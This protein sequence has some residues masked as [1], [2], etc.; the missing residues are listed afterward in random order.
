MQQQ[1][2]PMER[3]SHV[4]ASKY[5]CT[6]PRYTSYP[7]APQF[8]ETFPL[9]GYLRD[10][11]SGPK[12]AD[13]PMSLYVHIPFCRDICYYCA[14][15]KIVTREE[16]AGR[17]YLDHLSKELQLLESLSYKSRPITQLHWGGGTPTYLDNAELTELMHMLSRN[18]KLRDDD[19]REY[20]VEIDPRNV[21][22]DKIALLKGLGFNRI[23]MGIQDF[24]PL[25]QK[26]INRLQ[27]YREIEKL[28]A[29]VRSHDFSS[30]SFDLIYGLPYQDLDT[31]QNT[32][33][34][35]VQ[36]KPERIACYSY[37]HMPDRFPTQRSL[38]RMSLPSPEQKL[39][40]QALVADQLQAHGYVHI[41]MD[42]YALPTDDLAVAQRHGKLQRN[43]QGYTVQMAEDLLGLGVSAISQ[44][45]DYYLQNE[46]DLD[47]YYRR[48]ENSELPIQ[49][50]FIMSA[51]DRLHK[52]IIMSL[53]CN[54]KLDI[55]LCNS[56]FGIDFQRDFSKQ[57]PL[58]QDMAVDGLVTVESDQI[59]VTDAGRPFLRNI[60]MLFDEYL[61][62]DVICTSNPKQ[63]S[64]T[65]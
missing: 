47:T 3:L 43:F 62:T 42:H 19:S 26:S 33:A 41:G 23:S 7:T 55:N 37:A 46:R 60:C 12:N 25:V 57:L 21:P 34:K 53:I 52:H 9:D 54:L 4:L 29:E 11:A 65:T 44:I 2:N 14:C 35:V 32:V 15:N 51:Q 20:S 36:L 59:R 50:G 27:P 22:A 24:D 49:K 1:P 5:N 39:A 31:M 63:Y 38:D 30:L 17:K 40:L 64:A 58:L 16:G 18:F 10:A 61:H 45:G 13:A 8:S 48:L 6:G 56:L 28:V